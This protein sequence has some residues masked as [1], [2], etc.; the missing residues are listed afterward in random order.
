[1][2]DAVS[3]ETLQALVDAYPEGILATYHS[4]N[5]P[6]HFS[7]LFQRGTGKQVK[8]KQ[9]N[10]LVKASPDAA[11]K[12]NNFKYFPRHYASKRVAADEIMEALIKEKLP[13]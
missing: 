7:F 13:K 1:M 3:A 12:L 9:A 8:H 6:L 5:I 11:A 4:G 2:N 10:A